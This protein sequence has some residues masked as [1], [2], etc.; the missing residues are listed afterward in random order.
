[1][2]LLGL[3]A[4]T[5]YKA[6]YGVHIKCVAVLEW[7][8]NQLLHTQDCKHGVVLRQLHRAE[9][10]LEEL[11]TQA[12]RCTVKSLGLENQVLHVEEASARESA[13]KDF[14]QNELLRIQMNDIRSNV[15]SPCMSPPF[16]RLNMMEAHSSPMSPHILHTP[17]SQY[18]EVW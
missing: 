18:H 16:F 13:E 10:R 6:I 2:N 15:A 11:E 3:C 12:A 17:G 14:L 7:R 1:M 4:N 8:I 9:A 5:T